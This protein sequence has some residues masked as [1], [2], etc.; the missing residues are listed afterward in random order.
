LIVVF[1]CGGDRDRTKRPLM[2]AVA[3]RLADVVVLTSD[4]PR[5]EDPHVIV[6]EVRAGTAGP[7]QLRIEPDRAQAIAEALAAARAGDAVVIAGKGHESTQEIGGVSLPFDDVDIATTLLERQFGQGR[8]CDQ[9][10]GW[11]TTCSR[12]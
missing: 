8:D 11:G 12:S 5:S 2:G 6:D 10:G 1:G 4:N 7:G 9:P 3:T